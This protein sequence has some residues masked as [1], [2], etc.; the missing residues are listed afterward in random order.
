[1]SE[2][3]EKLFSVHD[4]LTAGGLSHAFGGA[5]ALAYCVK[6]PRGTRDLD[7]NI[8]T[9]STNAEAAL[10]SLPEDVSVGDEDISAVLRDG[11]TRLWWDDTPVDVFLN[12]LP[13]HDF[14]AAGIRW[15]PLAG[16][17]VPV[18]D[19]VSLAIFKAFFD[20]TKDWAD[21]ERIAE[22]IPRDIESAAAA[23]ARLVGPDDPAVGRLESLL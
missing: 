15:V 11:Q 19:C 21:L 8:F 10:G 5:I 16:R 23:V 17:E 9:A 18:L 7:V 2:L 6:E 13:L 14:V 22:T 20:R 12:N 4:G 1:M 3:V